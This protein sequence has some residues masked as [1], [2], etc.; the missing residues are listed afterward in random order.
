MHLDEI[1]TTNKKKAVTSTLRSRKR[2]ALDEI[3]V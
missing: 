1:G 2:F 3:N